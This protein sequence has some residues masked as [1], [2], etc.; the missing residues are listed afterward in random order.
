MNFARKIKIYLIAILLPAIAWIIINSFINGH[1]HRL[2]NGEIIYHAHPYDKHQDENLPIKSHHHTKIEY[3]LLCLIANPVFLLTSSFIALCVF[4]QSSNQIKSFY[5][6]VITLKEF[7]NL[8][9][10]RAPPFVSS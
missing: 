4:L 9:N 2:P 7:H 8:Q 10:P 5:S 1:Y 3:I 6:F